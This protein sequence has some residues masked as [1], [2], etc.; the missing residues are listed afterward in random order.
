MGI[1][2]SVIMPSLNVAAYIRK[3]MN[4]VLCQT[5]K[6]MEILCIDAGSTDGT[7]EILYDYARKDERVRIIHS[8]VKSYGVQVNMGIHIAKGTY[9]AIVETDDYIAEN[10]MER[11]Y[12]LALTYGLDYVKAEAN[13]IYAYNSG[14]VRRHLVLSDTDSSIYR[15]VINVKKT[16]QML[17]MDYYIWR[18]IYLRDFLLRNHIVC[19]ETKSA[20]YQDI[21]FCHLTALYARKVMYISDVFYQYRVGREGSSSACLNGLKYIYQEYKRLLEDYSYIENLP[22]GAEIFFYTRMVKAF[23]CEY[24]HT[25]RNT[26]YKLDNSLTGYYQWFQKYIK[27]RIHRRLLDNLCF[28]DTE[29]EDLLL[30][31]EKPCKYQIKLEMNDRRIKEQEESVLSKLRTKKVIIFGC[32]RW[33]HYVQELMYKYGKEV[34]AF[35]DNNQKLWNSVHDGV[36]VIPP[37]QI[38]AEMFDCS[39]IIANKRDRQAIEIQLL[40]LGVAPE[41]LIK[42]VG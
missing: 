35:C 25:I 1:K 11:L 40:E 17:A 12:M 29:W 31:L 5:L 33:G 38:P 10:M 39:Y 2:V 14:E 28:S 41:R 20:A 15:S 6:D 23:V 34:V 9:I 19:N 21:G 16:P 8:D 36:R 18:G 37:E 30:L 42:Y 26:D 13:A 7:L 4:S 3:C 22:E 32:G 24:V 27:D